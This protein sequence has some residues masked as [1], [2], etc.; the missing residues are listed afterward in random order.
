MKLNNLYSET[1]DK[2]FMWI[3]AGTNKSFLDASNFVF[4]TEKEQKLVLRLHALKK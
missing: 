1:L 4:T 2:S 3:D